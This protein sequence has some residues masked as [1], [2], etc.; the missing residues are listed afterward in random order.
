[1]PRNPQFIA[2]IAL[3]TLVALGGTTLAAQDP[4]MGGGFGGDHRQGEGEQVRH[5]ATI[6]DEQIDGPPYPQFVNVRFELDSTEAAAYKQLYD[7][8]MVA[9]QPQRDSARA[10]RSGGRHHEAAGSAP[11]PGA[12]MAQM[13]QVEQLS[14]ELNKQQ[15][16]FDKRLKKVLSSAHYKDYKE[17]RDDQRKQ[18]EAAQGTDSRP[19]ER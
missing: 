4:G 11:D 15:S 14:N 17:W 7:S 10:L 9:T 18:A 19:H 5:R 16:Q 3:S 1:M 2:F 13:D 8:F 12:L 6:T